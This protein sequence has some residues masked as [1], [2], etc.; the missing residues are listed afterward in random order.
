MLRGIFNRYDN[1]FD[2]I[3]SLF[4]VLV[5]EAKTISNY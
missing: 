4:N 3:L 1:F 2:E 5:Y